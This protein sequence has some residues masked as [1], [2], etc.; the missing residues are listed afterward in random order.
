MI[1]LSLGKKIGV[2]QV[3]TNMNRIDYFAQNIVMLISKGK[4]ES[5][6]KV[7]EEIDQKHI[8]HYLYEKYRTDMRFIPIESVYEEDAD[9]WENE[10]N[11]RFAGTPISDAGNKWGIFNEEDGLL[12]LVSLTLEA[13]R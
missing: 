6:Q 2:R 13:L 10:Y 4:K 11:R 5:I 3:N 12:L 9:I 1:L 7:L 8:V